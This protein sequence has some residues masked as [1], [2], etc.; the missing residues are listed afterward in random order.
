MFCLCHFAVF[1]FVKD[2]VT[3]LVVEHTV[4]PGFTFPFICVTW[5]AL[6]TDKRR[7]LFVMVFLLL[8]LVIVVFVLLVGLLVLQ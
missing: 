2:P 5:L 1:G 8:F 4:V 7:G 3:H 6:M